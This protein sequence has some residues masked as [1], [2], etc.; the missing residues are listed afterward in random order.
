MGVTASGTEG[1]L[2]GKGCLA[3]EG[4]ELSSVHFVGPRSVGRG[5]LGRGVALVVLKG[6]VGRGWPGR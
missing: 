5:F 4:S 1:Q 3:G 6:P 2:P